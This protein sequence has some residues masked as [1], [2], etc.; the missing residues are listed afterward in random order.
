MTDQLTLTERMARAQR[1]ERL[2]EDI[3]PHLVS[4]RALYHAEWEKALKPET[5]E[6]LWQK[7]MA[8]TD[9]ERDIRTTISD[10]AVARQIA[11]DQL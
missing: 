8:L 9:V 5:R 1:A 3:Q 7:L 4:V 11:E 10:G 6:L 2:N